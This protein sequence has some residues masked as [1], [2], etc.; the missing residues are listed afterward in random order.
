MPIRFQ[1]QPAPN[2][3]RFNLDFPG[4]TPKELVADI[5]RAMGRPVNVIV[6]ED[7]NAVRL[8]ALKMNSIDVAQLF[9]A[10]SLRGQSDDIVLNG[11][12][13]ALSYL[14]E[15]QPP[16][17]DDSIWTF[18]MSKQGPLSSP[19]PQKICRF[20]A[21]S[22]YLERG[23]TVDDITTAIETGWKMLQLTPPAGASLPSELRRKPEISF[24]KDT[25]LLIAVGEPSTLEVIDDALKALAPRPPL[26]GEDFSE[27]LR[28]TMQQSGVSAPPPGAP[29]RLP[30]RPKTEK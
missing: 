30:E 2:L 21:L 8:P 18:Q 5:E 14:F 26:P 13:Y 15:A 16:Y 9:H 17:S 10:L 3:T 27:R 20:Y 11:Q 28:R 24:H 12:R 7:A 19:S 23:L 1:S 6:P 4:G 22:P 25:K 29:A